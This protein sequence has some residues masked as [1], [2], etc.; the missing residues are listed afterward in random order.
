MS[1]YTCSY[2]SINADWFSKHVGSELGK[3]YD[4]YLA[5]FSKDHRNVHKIHK[6]CDV[7][8]G[9]EAELAELSSLQP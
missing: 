2:I 6:A 1:R 9:Q 3:V 5:E 8:N 4:C 7:L